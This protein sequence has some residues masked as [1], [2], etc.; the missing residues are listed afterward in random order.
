MTLRVSDW[1]SESDLD[2]IRNS[3]DVLY[4]TYSV[5]VIVVTTILIRFYKEKEKVERTASLQMTAPTLS[6]TFTSFEAAIIHHHH[7]YHH[8]H[9]HRHHYHH[10]HHGH[11]QHISSAMSSCQAEQWIV[12]LW[13][14]T[15]PKV[16]FAK[17]LSRLLLW[18]LFR[19]F[20]RLLSRLL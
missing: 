15:R 18:L 4:N 6:R 16:N 12:V 9:L 20:S 19:L 13:T 3:S 5:I 10:H 7:H 1:Q 14:T 8:H 17:L 2:S 11:H